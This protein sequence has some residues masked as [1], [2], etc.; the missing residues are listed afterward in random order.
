MRDS[1]RA[2]LDA[3]GD[4]RWLLDRG[5]PVTASVKLVGDRHRLDRESR[6]VLYRGVS[7]A[8]SCLRRSSLL[9]GPPEDREVWVDGYNQLFTVANYL[10]GRRLFLSA[11]GLLRDAGAVHGR[12][13]R[14]ATF[15]RAQ[16]LLAEALASCAPSRLVLRFDSPVSGSAHHARDFAAALRARGLETEA[17]LDR[18][19]DFPLKSAPPGSSVA[20]SDS[21][22][23]DALY[24]RGGVT[25]FDAARYALERAFGPDWLDLGAALSPGGQT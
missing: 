8:P 2:L 7:D 24:S 21:V 1:D 25:L 12:I 3:A 14:E 13:S 6:L 11:D 20:T 17:F 15:L 10:D 22:V 4:Y 5:Y 16:D 18:S 9:S 23:A 19:A